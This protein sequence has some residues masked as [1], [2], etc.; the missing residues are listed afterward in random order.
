MKKSSERNV[1]RENK[2]KLFGQF[3]AAIQKFKAPAENFLLNEFFVSCWHGKEKERMNDEAAE[4]C[5]DA[6]RRQVRCDCPV[7]R[8]WS[9]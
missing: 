3:F 9:R 8:L 6:K 2:K 1:R 7:P 4:T 5:I